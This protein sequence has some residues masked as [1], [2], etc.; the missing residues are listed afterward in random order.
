MCKKVFGIV[1]L[2]HYCVRPR[3]TSHRLSYTNSPSRGQK[4]GRL[5][6]LFFFFFFLE[7]LKFL[8]GLILVESRL[9][10]ICFPVVVV[11]WNACVLVRVC[12]VRRGRYVL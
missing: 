8:F 5:G 10:G 12:V 4:R 2:A 6:F 7:S 3:C 9:L 1:N 11:W